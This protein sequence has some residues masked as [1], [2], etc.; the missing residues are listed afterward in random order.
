MT[1]KAFQWA[2]KNKSS[3]V[4][5]V[6]GETEAY[7]VLSDGFNLNSTDIHESEQEGNVEVEERSSFFE[8]ISVCFKP[9]A[10]T[11]H[12]QHQGL[13]PE[14]YNTGIWDIQMFAVTFGKF[15]YLLQVPSSGTSS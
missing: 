13:A 14:M 15:R 6:H 2:E 5:A 8:G 1:E 7:L 4:N 10:Y 11:S 9:L 3:R 12:N